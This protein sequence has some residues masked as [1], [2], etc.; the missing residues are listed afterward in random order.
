[1][2]L[3]KKIMNLKFSTNCVSFKHIIGLS[4]YVLNIS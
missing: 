2:M 4:I 3:Q 1:M